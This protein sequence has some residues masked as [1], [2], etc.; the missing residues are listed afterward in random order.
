MVESHKGLTVLISD[1][2]SEDGIKE[3]KASGNHV[4]YEHSLNGETLTKA[5]HEH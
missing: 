1:L 3:L 2:F 5:L 4:I